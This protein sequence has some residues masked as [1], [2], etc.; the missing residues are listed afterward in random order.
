MDNSQKPV[1]EWKQ[2]ELAVASFIKALDTNSNVTH[3]ART[4]DGDTGYPR[5]RDIWIEGRLCNLFPIKVLVSCK[6]YNRELNE[7]DIDHFVGELISSSAD[8]GVIYSF[9]GFNAAAVTKAKAHNISCMKLYL[10]EPPDIPEILIIPQS[11]C[12]YPRLRLSTL[13]KI[14]PDN[15]IRVWDDILEQPSGEANPDETLLDYIYSIIS[16]NQ[17]AVT[18][19]IPSNGY[20]PIDW[21][22]EC[23]FIDVAREDVQIRIRLVQTWE[24]FEALLEA[25]N[26]NGTYSLTEK[27]F[28]GGITTPFIDTWSSEPGPGWK[29]CLK[30][31]SPKDS[32]ISFTFFFGDIRA[33]LKEFYG[34]KT[35]N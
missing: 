12:C 34:P 8:K 19:K 20:L 9:N 28:I 13:W 18:E 1:P 24:I 6:R 32:H 10:D 5:Q 29:K 33:G 30:R 7:L 23:T 16:Q 15:K 27:E 35:I 17:K 2:F 31:P 4:P 11:Y 25:Y 21:A 3:D 14:D 26:V 22:Y